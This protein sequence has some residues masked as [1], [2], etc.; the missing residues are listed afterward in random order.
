MV[1]SSSLEIKKLNQHIF[2]PWNLKMKDLLV[3]K[4]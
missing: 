3:D 1:S 2:E 4:E